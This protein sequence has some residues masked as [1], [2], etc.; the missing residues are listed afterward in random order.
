M[1]QHRTLS[2]RA[3]GATALV[4]S[5]AAAAYF[6][7]VAR[8]GPGPAGGTVA[9]NGTLAA[10][11]YKDVAV[12]NGAS[13]TFGSGVLIQHDLT[14]GQGGLLSATGGSVGHDLQAQQ[15]AILKLAG[16]SIGNNLQADTPA[17]VG[18]TGAQVSHDL[19][20]DGTTGA[21]P[22]P[23]GQNYVCATT[24]GHDLNV[25]NSA[26]GA[27]P[28][29]LGTPAC[30]GANTVGHNTNTDNNLTA[31]V[32]PGQSS[33]YVDGSLLAQA[34]ASPSGTF[35]V[36]IEGSGSQGSKNVQDA[37]K[38]LPKGKA[39]GFRQKLDAIDGGSA[40]LTGAQLL[41]LST[42]PGIMAITPDSPVQLAGPA[43]KN[44]PKN[45][46]LSNTQQWPFAS[47]VAA[48]WPSAGDGTLPTPPAIAI[49]DSGIQ[50]NRKDFDKHRVIDQVDLA[51]LP[52]DSHGDGYGHGTFVAGIAAGSAQGYA[53]A[54]PSAPIVSIDVMND[55]GEALTSDVIAACDWIIANKKKDNIGVANFSLHSSAPA[56]VYWDPLDKAVESL[57]FDGVTVVAASGNYAVDG[58]ASGVRFAPANDPFVI[59]VGAD[60]LHGT[61]SAQDDTAAPWSSWGYTYDGFAKPE[62]S[63]PGRYLIGPV[64]EHSTLATTRP[65]DMVGKDYI[66]LSGTSFAAPVVSGAAAYLLALHPDWTPDQ[67]KGALMLSAQA[68]PSATPMSEGVGLVDLAAAAKVTN[69]PNPNL[70]LDQFLVPDPAG[71]SLPVF[72]TASWS[73]AA[74][75]DASW[76]DASWSDASWS[77]ASWSDA[78]WSDASWSDASW[79]TASWSDASWSD[80]SWSDAS[81]SDASWSDASWSDNAQADEGV[82][83]LL[84]AVQIAVAEAELGITIGPDGSVSAGP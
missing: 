82:A 14:V 76:S 7:G 65:G 68:T 28:W 29:Y 84:D 33:A 46:P 2:S 52:G 53:G 27:G 72:D 70:A 58:Q 24:V 49:V 16:L 37:V 12:P 59:T 11:T 34:E 5:V 55:Q 36:I 30:G 74:R 25:K 47:G 50:D 81:W 35:D 13:C 75:S 54:A 8:P 63:A 44:D 32:Q 40:Q 21:G 66:Q 80:A 17:G 18:I 23:L 19:S 67:V 77:D 51:S 1:R 22:G 78:S 31:V 42:T 26:Q 83:A 10:G 64:P 71:G 43:P 6:A 3:A 20:I 60:D 39:V 61:V 79:A 57:W 9:C 69:P 15:G 56:S 4:A 38:H 73:D 45:D 48:G 62:I 41:N